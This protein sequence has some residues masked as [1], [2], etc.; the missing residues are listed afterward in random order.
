[1]SASGTARGSTRY[2][3]GTNARRARRVGT[4]C[5]AAAVL[6]GGE[7][8]LHDLDTQVGIGQVREPLPRLAQQRRHRVARDVDQLDGDQNGSTVTSSPAATSPR[9][10]SST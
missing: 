10:S 8:T 6:G 2:T 7:A 1:M 4:G 9:G 3:A 5:A